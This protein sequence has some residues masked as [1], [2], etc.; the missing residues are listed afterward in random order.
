MSKKKIKVRVKKRKLNIKRIILCLLVIVVIIILSY[1]ISKLPIKNI[2]IIGNNIVSDKEIIDISGISDYPSFI[3]ISS[4]K[5]EKKLKE[6]IYIKNVEIKKKSLGKLY[7]YVNEK[8]ILCTYENKLVLEDSNIIEN[9]H[10]ITSYPILLSDIS[11]IK[12]KFITQFSLINDEILLKISEIE[13]TPNDVDNERFTLKMNDDN[14]VYITLSKIEKINKYNSIYS[15]L[16]GKKG[17]I[18]LDSG[19]YVEIKEE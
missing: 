16:E 14:L 10:N 6:N 13:Y 2:Y 5:T 9:T 11:D 17:I 18:Y 1:F 4:R 15:K 12:D 7:I 3:S 19:D 8:K